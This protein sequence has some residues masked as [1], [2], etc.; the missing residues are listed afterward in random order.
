VSLFAAF[1]NIPIFGLPLISTPSFTPKPVS[2]RRIQDAVDTMLSL[3]NSDGG[4]AS[5][6]LIRA[7]SWSE[8]LNPAEVFGEFSLGYPT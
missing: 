8:Y 5:Y 7:G 4:F 6:E 2:A 3:Q 1:F